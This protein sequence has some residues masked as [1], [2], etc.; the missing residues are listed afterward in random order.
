MEDCT[1]NSY[2][3]HTLEARFCINIL[4]VLLSHQIMWGVY[5][6]YSYFIDEAPRA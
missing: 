2:K 4:Y 5:L 6:D 3:Q 1:A